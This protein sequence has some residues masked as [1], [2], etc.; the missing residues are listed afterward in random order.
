MSLLENF[1]HTCTAKLR[2]V[3]TGSLGGGES[4]FSTVFTGRA[5]WILVSDKIY[6]LTNPGLDERHIVEV[7]KMHGRA[8]IADTDTLEVRTKAVPDATVGLGIVYRIF[9]EAKTS[10]GDN[11]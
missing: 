4:S 7:S 5:C 2:T 1:P 8:S 9:V 11:I 6:F 3:T 10:R